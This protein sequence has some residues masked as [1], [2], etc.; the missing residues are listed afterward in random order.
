MPSWQRCFGLLPLLAPQWHVWAFAFAGTV[1]AQPRP[2]NAD[3]AR[4]D[5]ARRIEH[6]KEN[7]DVFTWALSEE[8]MG[9]L[10][11]MAQ[12]N[13]T[14]GDPFMQGDPEAVHVNMIGPTV[15]C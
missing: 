3:T 14:R 6:M 12:C 1:F 4:T 2:A 7:L 5:V 9:R 15:H 10:S 13:V 11:S 8:D